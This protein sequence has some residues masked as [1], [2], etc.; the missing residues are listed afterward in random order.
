MLCIAGRTLH[1]VNDDS[2]RERQMR[3]R[4][5]SPR[6]DDIGFSPPVPSSSSGQAGGG[7]SCSYL[8]TTPSSNTIML[9][10]RLLVL[11]HVVSKSNSLLLLLFVAKINSPF[12]LRAVRNPCQREKIRPLPFKLAIHWC[13][14]IK[15][16]MRR[17]MCS[18]QPSL[19]PR[20]S[21]QHTV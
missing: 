7:D 19:R 9:F 20:A 12:L 17:I 13:C 18:Q 15:S 10:H 3:T 5:T 14:W 8:S 6:G 16:V 4:Y 11:C 1:T 2:T 21:L